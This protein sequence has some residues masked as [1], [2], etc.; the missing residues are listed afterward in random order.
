MLRK[1]VLNE[2]QAANVSELNDVNQFTRRFFNRTLS[3]VTGEVTLNNNGDCLPNL[4]IHQLDPETGLIA[5]LSQHQHVIVNRP[6]LKILYLYIAQNHFKARL[7]SNYFLLAYKNTCAPSFA[8]CSILLRIGQRTSSSP[9]YVDSLDE[10]RGADWQTA[11][12]L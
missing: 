2:S 1:Q 5:V 10:W 7:A 4:L 12:R 3:L 9:Q 8:A 11:L 6:R